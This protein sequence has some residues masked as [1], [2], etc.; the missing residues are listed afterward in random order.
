M[1]GNH[2]NSQLGEA[3]MTFVR[4]VKGFSHAGRGERELVDLNALLENVLRV[5]APQLRHRARIERRFAELP[6]VSCAQQEIKQVL[7]NVV[8]NARQALGPEGGEIQLGTEVLGSEVV[9]TIQDDGCGIPAEAIERLF[10]PFFTTKPGGEGTGL[11][12]V[13]LRRRSAS[14]RTGALAC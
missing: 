11:G 2:T 10:D 4:D 1:A 9:V 5:A 3:L 7:L 12:L 6:L 13:T 14:A 8:L